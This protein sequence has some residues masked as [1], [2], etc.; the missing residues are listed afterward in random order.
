M[1]YIYAVESEE[2]QK[3]SGLLSLR[4][5]LTEDDDRKLEDIMDPFV[6]TLNPLDSAIKAAYRVMDSGLA[7][8][9]VVGREGILIGVVPIDVAIEQIA[10]VS[11]VTGQLRIFS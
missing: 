9:P 4:N 3:L 7:A 2:S 5:L 11:G 8:M 6:S 10:P 1:F